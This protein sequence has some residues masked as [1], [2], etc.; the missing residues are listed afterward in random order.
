MIRFG[1]IVFTNADIG[2]DFKIYRSFSHLLLPTGRS[3]NYFI[4][5]CSGGQVHF[6][7]GSDDLTGF[8]FISKFFVRLYPSYIVEEEPDMQE[9]SFRRY[10]TRIGDRR[11]GEFY[12]PD[13]ID[14]IVSFHS[15]FPD[16]PLLYAC[17]IISGRTH[18][19]KRY[20]VYIDIGIGPSGLRSD[21][22]FGVFEETLNSLKTRHGVRLRRVRLN[23]LMM[24]DNM[25]FPFN[26]INFVR[27]PADVNV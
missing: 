13:L 5:Q 9:Y 10:I 18:T 19:G 14:D 23:S 1:K 15:T 11:S 12:F 7:L 4:M 2:T 25:R 17:G 24:D 27:V 21:S 8:N 26:L 6:F 22:I 3:T 16:I 20:S